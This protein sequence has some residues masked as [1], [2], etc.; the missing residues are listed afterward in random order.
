M[1]SLNTSREELFFNGKF[2]KK[3][4]GSSTLFIETGSYIGDGINGA[5]LADFN[6]IISIELSEQH[7]KHCQ[8]RFKNNDNVSIML[9]DSNEVLPRVLADNT[10]HRN[11]F[12]W[13]DAHYSGG[14][15]VGEDLIHTLSNELKIIDSYLAKHSANIILAVDDLDTPTWTKASDL[16]KNHLTKIIEKETFIGIEDR[17]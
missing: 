4:R 14:E 13:L 9:G 10:Q 6:K 8:E 15:T 16:I 1:A 7:Y 2:F 12:I 17:F 3:Y 5:I 11:I